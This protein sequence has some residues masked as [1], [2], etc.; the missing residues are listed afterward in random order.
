METKFAPFGS[1]NSS[2][3]SQSKQPT[4]PSQKKLHVWFD[5]STF[6]KGQKA[7]IKVP[8][9]RKIASKICVFPTEKIA[10]DKWK[11]IQFS[12]RRFGI[13]NAVNMFL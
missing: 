12:R 1:I 4:E 7:Y 9:K 13:L 5:A 6:C 11:K 3:D 2:F 10:N 8:K